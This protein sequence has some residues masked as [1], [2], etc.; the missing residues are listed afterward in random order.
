MLIHATTLLLGEIGVVIRGASGAGKS[1]LAAQWL[2]SPPRLPHMGSALICRLVA[3]DQTR[4]CAQNGRLLAGAPA[5]LVGLLEMRG[6]GIASLKA[7][8]ST[9]SAFLHGRYEKKVDVGLVIDRVESDRMPENG[10][11]TVVLEG[12]PLPRLVLSPRLPD[13]TAHFILAMTYFA[14]YRS[15]FPAPASSFPL[16]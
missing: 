11:E 14:A 6:L 16:P 8:N 9:P 1:S 12:I 7:T 2:A 15:I 13:P 4:I 3:D 10:E 5:S